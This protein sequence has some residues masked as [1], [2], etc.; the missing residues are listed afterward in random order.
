MLLAGGSETEA[1]AQEEAAEGGLAPVPIRG[2]GAA[3]RAVVP[4]TTA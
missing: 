2:T 4:G 1:E 3:R